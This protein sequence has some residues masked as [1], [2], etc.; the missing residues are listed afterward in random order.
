MDRPMTPR[1]QSLQRESFAFGNA[2]FENERVTRVVADT[3]VRR[4]ASSS[5]KSR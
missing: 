2:R 4:M 3:A 5:S 1:E